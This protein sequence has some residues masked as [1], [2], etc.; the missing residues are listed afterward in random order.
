MSWPRVG[1]QWGKLRATL[2][3]VLGVRAPAGAS[4]GGGQVCFRGAGAPGLPEGAGQRQ[5][6]PVQLVT[7]AQHAPV[8]SALL[9]F[10]IASRCVL[11]PTS[12]SLVFPEC[13]S[14]PKV[15]G[16]VAH[17]FLAGEV[18]SVQPAQATLRSLNSQGAPPPPLHH[19]LGRPSTQPPP[20]HPCSPSDCT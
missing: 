9:S 7:R 6:G 14:D 3:W 15:T 16:I 11:G 5:P 4:P 12:F 17:T 19:C 1:T 10:P 13:G 18:R 8:G 2:R 20:C